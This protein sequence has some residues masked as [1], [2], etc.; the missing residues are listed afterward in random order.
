MSISPHERVIFF[1]KERKTESM[2]D[3][4]HFYLLLNTLSSSLILFPTRNPA[5]Q[6]TQKPFERR[7]AEQGESCLR[8]DGILYS[9]LS[10][11]QA[12]LIPLIVKVHRRG[13]NLAQENGV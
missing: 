7:A 1:T 13:K 6:F 5:R 8:G 10:W 4:W 3:S 11:W 2:C 12:T 9:R